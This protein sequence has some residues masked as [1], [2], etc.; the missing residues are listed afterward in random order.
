MYV[1]CVSKMLWHERERYSGKSYN[2]K[3]ACARDGKA[4]RGDEN[5]GAGSQRKQRTRRQMCSTNVVE[6][7]KRGSYF[8]RIR[9]YRPWRQPVAEGGQGSE[10]E[11]L[12]A[13]RVSNRGRS[14]MSNSFRSTRKKPGPT[15]TRG[16]LKVA[17]T[18]TKSGRKR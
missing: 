15:W 4:L 18:G 13:I 3:L 17:D 8:P 1:T 14:S 2:Y 7:T 10:S 12:I 16:R 5:Y 9:K 6:K 11:D